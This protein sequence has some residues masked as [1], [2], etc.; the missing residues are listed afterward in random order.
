MQF[1]GDAM[2]FRYQWLY[3]PGRWWYFAG[4]P[5][6]GLPEVI[7]GTRGS[8]PGPDVNEVSGLA[9]QDLLTDANAS[10]RSMCT[11]DPV[12]GGGCIMNRFSG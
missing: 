6:A 10:W 4:S 9:I 2:F 5:P 12:E 1:S 8:P 7:M 3:A 11:P